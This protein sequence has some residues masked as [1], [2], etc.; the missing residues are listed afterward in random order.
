MEITKIIKAIMPQARPAK[1]KA[2]QAAK[3]KEASAEPQPAEAPKTVSPKDLMQAVQDLEVRFNLKVVMA[4][5]EATGREVVRIFSED[6]KRL[7]RQMPPDQVLH[8]A[9]QARQGTLENLLNSRV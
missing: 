7:L 5:D 3:A 4:T 9:A 8:M 6:G 1:P 2:E